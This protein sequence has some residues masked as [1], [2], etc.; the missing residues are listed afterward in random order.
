[1]GIIIV[2]VVTIRGRNFDVTVPSVDLLH[3]S[4]DGSHG[5]NPAYMGGEIASLDPHTE[6]KA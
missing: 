4:D 1:V 6:K 3:L 5:T 2:V